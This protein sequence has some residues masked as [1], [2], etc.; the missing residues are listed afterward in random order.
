MSEVTVFKLSQCRDSDGTF[1]SKRQ[2]TVTKIREDKDDKQNLHPNLL[3]IVDYAREFSE[4]QIDHFDL[5]L[6]T[7]LIFFSYIPCLLHPSFGLYCITPI[8]SLMF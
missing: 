4:S 6:N 7:V 8:R 3:I 1:L 5:D 2:T